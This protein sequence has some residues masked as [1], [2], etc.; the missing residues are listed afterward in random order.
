METYS[1]T[2][3]GV[4]TESRSGFLM[5]TYAHVVGAIAA[6]VGIEVLLFQSGIAMQIAAPL[7]NNWLLVIG[8]LVLV[9][10]LV[11]RF[12]TSAYSKPV[13]YGVLAAF[14]AVEALIFVPLIFAA[15]AYAGSAILSQ[16]ALITL[17]MLAAVSVVVYVFRANFTFL[18]PFLAIL[19]IAALGLIVASLLFGFQLGIWFSFAMVTYATG[20]MLYQTSKIQYEYGEGEYVA[21]SVGLLASIFLMLWYVIQLLLGTQE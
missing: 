8:G 1:Q 21:A 16:A 17:G 7:A 6:F 13:Q 3:S 15:V 4:A 5:K 9:S 14:V 18:G 20:A 11:S 2:I 12:A 19:G 10:Y